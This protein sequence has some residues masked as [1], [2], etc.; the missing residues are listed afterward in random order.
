MVPM[1]V[2]YLHKGR[3]MFEAWEIVAFSCSRE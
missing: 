3:R 2:E 1:E